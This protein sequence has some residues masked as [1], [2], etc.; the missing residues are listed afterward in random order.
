MKKLITTSILLAFL[1]AGNI[2]MAQDRP[3][4]ST[5]LPGDNLNLYAVM[6][7]F[8]ESATLEEFEKALN[9]ENSRIN[10]LDL[11]GD[12]MVDYIRV[13]D[14]EDGDVHNIVLQVTINERENQDVAVFT[15]QRD[16]Y[17]QVQIQ[18]TGDADLYGKDYIIEPILD[19]GE[20]GQTPN[21]GYEG[22]TRSIDGRDIVVHRTTTIEIAAW[23][24]IRFLYLPDYIIWRSPWY[25]G[26]YPPYWHPWRPFF[27]DY[28]YG[29]HYNW[30]NDYYA[31]YRRWHFHRYNR[32][33]DNYWVNRRAHSFYVSERIH[34]GNYKDTYSRPDQ[35]RDGEALYSRTHQ[36]QN[37][38]R[39]DASTSTSAGR[40]SGSRSVSEGQSNEKNTTR[41][42][43][44]NMRNSQGSNPSS[45]QSTDKTRRSTN[46]VTNK[47][48]SNPSSDQSSV[49]TRRST[50][51]ITNKSVSKP[52]SGQSMDRTRR[53]N[54]TVSNRSV[55]NQQSGQKAG[56]TRSSRQ[57]AA[58]AKS[59]TRRSSGSDRST[60]NSK[61]AEKTKE[62]SNTKSS[63]R[64]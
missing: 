20:S 18:L 34:S 57:P 8:R 46:T 62:N 53:S 32:W 54:S 7:L 10:N 17:G 63:R 52:S 41:R 64:N 47:S 49:K 50:N 19:E 26:Y 55:S 14:F 48:G 51:T 16:A 2:I 6:K 44:T 58:G 24:M 29:Y 4:E 22:N 60:V 5:G 11:D 30:Y 25:Y 21:P 39:S 33:N 27:W 43:N 3:A 37:S 23:P 12:N 36:S 15:V 42:S 59:S 9:D 40:R 45:G 38:G 31:N 13:I 35:R 61:K 1:T 56:T 28:Y